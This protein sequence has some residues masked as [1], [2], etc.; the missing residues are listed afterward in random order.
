[1]IT[2]SNMPTVSVSNRWNFFIG[3]LEA[4]DPYHPLWQD[5]PWPMPHITIT[6]P[7][8]HYEP[9]QTV[10]WPAIGKRKKRNRK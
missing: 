8:M 10:K 2:I 3:L 4:T 6:R 5:L 7:T 9:F 1:M